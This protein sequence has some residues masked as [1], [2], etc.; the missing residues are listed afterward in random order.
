MSKIALTFFVILGQKAGIRMNDG[1]LTKYWDILR[2][3]QPPLASVSKPHADLENCSHYVLMQLNLQLL[4]KQTA[5]RI[6]VQPCH[7]RLQPTDA[8]LLRQLQTAK[9]QHCDF[10]LDSLTQEVIWQRKS[11]NPTSS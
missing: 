10:G 4:Q 8:R 5:G 3:S 9:G 2:R 1:L 11:E 6:S 7:V